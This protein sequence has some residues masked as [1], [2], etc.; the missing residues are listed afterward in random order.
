MRAREGMFWP[1]NSADISTLA[2][3]CAVCEK[4]KR[5]TTMLRHEI[6]GL[7]WQVVELYTF[8]HNDVLP[9]PCG[10]LLLI[11]FQGSE[12]MSNTTGSDEQCMYAR[13][14]DSWNP[15]KAVQR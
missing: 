5:R 7:S 15:G 12:A 9:N 1:N 3:S 10:F 8:Y 4:Y 14:Y 6:P 2:K 13:L 11:L